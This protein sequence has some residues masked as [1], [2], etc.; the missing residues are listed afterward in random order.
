MSNHVH[1]SLLVYH[2]EY[3]HYDFGPEHPL[4]PERLHSGTSLL[5]ALELWN[6][7]SVPSHGRASERELAL[8]HTPD[9]ISAVRHA[10]RPDSTDVSLARFGIGTRD[11][12]RFHNMHQAAAL[13]AGGAI[14]AVRSVLNGQ[15]DHAFHPFG[16][17]HHAMRGRASG[18]CIYND[19]A[20][21]AAV[22][23]HEYGARVLY[24]DYDSHHG[25]GVQAIFYQRPDVFTLS[26]HES[27][28]FLFPG[29]GFVE[30]R[31]TGPGEGYTL[32]VPFE[33]YSRDED[34]L[35]AVEDIVPEVAARF[36]PDLI[37]SAHG[38]DT[39]RDDPLTHMALTTRSFAAQA[40]LTHTLAHTY[41]QGRWVAFGSGGYDWRSVVPRS[42]AIL[43]AEMAG[44]DLPVSIPDRW[45]HRW[46]TDTPLPATLHDAPHP[47]VPTPMRHDGPSANARTIATALRSV[48]A[49]PLCHETSRLR[50]G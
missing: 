12:P 30:E 44:L 10:E 20:L 27:G 50:L 19:A 7:P 32:N 37:L 3:D 1:R 48:T 8:V 40:T 24:V 22:A 49:V 16:G 38:A 14:H 17:L 34:W 28:R 13:V 15:V 33:P 5:Q 21:A 35:R 46:E 42:W 23:A 39:H 43:W 25:D 18:F 9:L 26:F 47:P 6:P 41:S 31:G 4:R 36:R 29:T 45:R 2:P 11:N